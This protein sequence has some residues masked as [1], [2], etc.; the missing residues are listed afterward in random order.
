MLTTILVCTG[1]YIVS[2]YAVGAVVMFLEHKNDHDG[3]L[4]LYCMLAPVTFPIVAALY[5]RN[6]YYKVK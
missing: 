6:K 5:L 3:K 2:C 1:G 4:A